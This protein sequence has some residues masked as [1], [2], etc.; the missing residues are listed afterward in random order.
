MR[1][2]FQTLCFAILHL[3]KE[4]MAS[5]GKRTLLRD[6]NP[7]LIC[8]LCRGYLIDATTVVEC[9]HSCKQNRNLNCSNFSYCST[10]MINMLYFCHLVCRSCI[11]KYLNTAAHCPS[12]KHA[13]NK[14]KPNI[15]YDYSSFN[16][17]NNL[18][19]SFILY[20]FIVIIYGRLDYFWRLFK[21]AISL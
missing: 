16:L 3:H 11:L 2:S 1:F 6:I 18:H 20:A 8:L 15:K 14:A 21:I 10:A 12:C 4:E 7:H 13:I 9:L 5:I 19:M 17:Y